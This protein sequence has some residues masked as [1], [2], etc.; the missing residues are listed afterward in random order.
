MKER[1]IIRGISRREK[2]EDLSKKNTGRKIRSEREKR[3]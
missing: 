2:T 1:A 3:K